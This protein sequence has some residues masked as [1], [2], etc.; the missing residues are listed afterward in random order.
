VTLGDMKR[1]V[2]EARRL[3]PDGG[4]QVPPHLSD[5]WPELV[6]ACATDLGG[7]S[8]NGDHISP[9]RSFLRRRRSAGGWFRTAGRCSSGFACTRSSSIQN[10]SPTR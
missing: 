2:A 10:E 7:L 5:W 9:E 1:L 6:A 3:M 8:P 4:V